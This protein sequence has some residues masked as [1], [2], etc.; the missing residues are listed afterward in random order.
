MSYIYKQEPPF[1][2]QIETT[3]GCNLFCTFCGLR[4]IQEKSGGP[5]R[6]MTK[7]ILTSLITQVTDLGWN[8]RVEFAMHGEPTMHPDYIGMV[9][10]AYSIHPKLQLMLTTN[11]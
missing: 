9:A 6:F 3:Q 5:Y 4:G 8:P 2:L 10:L 1:S 7:E 11:G